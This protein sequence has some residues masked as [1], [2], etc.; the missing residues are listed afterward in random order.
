MHI[1]HDLLGKKYIPFISTLII[2]FLNE[3]IESYTY[4]TTKSI[5]RTA[6]YMPIYSH[7]K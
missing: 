1:Y 2:I 7:K 6:R 5:W 4:A 3:N